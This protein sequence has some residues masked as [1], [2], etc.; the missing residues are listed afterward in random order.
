MVEFL[1]GFGLGLVAYHFKDQIIAFVTG[2]F[3][4]KE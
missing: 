2:L 3:N 1:V 4:N